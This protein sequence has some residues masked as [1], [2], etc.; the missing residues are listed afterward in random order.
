MINALKG[1][2]NKVDDVLLWSDSVSNSTHIVTDSGLRVL[3]GLIPSEPVIPLWNYPVKE[4]DP[5]IL[6]SKCL[7]FY[8]ILNK[9]KE[10]YQ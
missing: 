6:C 4:I 3:C 7:S 8:K 5:R 2:R 1:G 10:E 9:L